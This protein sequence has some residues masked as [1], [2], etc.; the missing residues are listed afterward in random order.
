[1]RWVFSPE[2]YFE[3]IRREASA[4]H[5]MDLLVAGVGLPVLGAIVAGG[6]ALLSGLWMAALL[7]GLFIAISVVIFLAAAISAPKVRWLPP[8]R[9]DFVLKGADHGDP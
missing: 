3:R 8:S 7:F 1:M 9:E 2:R 4:E 5:R 6:A